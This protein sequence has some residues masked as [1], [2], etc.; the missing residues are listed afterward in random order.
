MNCLNVKLTV[1]FSWFSECDR[2]EAMKKGKGEK[3]KEREEELAGG[4]PALRGAEALGQ[5]N[6]PSNVQSFLT[7]FNHF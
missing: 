7:T 2:R 6:Y 5:R 1:R 4:T 3:V